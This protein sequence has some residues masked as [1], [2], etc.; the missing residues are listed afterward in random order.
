M[1]PEML[2]KRICVCSGGGATTFD[3]SEG[4]RERTCRGRGSVGVRAAPATLVSFVS[5]NG[6]TLRYVL[7][8]TTFPRFRETHE[9]P[10][11]WIK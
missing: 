11:T 4:D 6:A 7:S 5:L 2:A 3:N 8:R 10:C 9:I 1:I